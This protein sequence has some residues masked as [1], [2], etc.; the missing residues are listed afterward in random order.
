MLPARH[1][2]LAND[3]QVALRGDAQVQGVVSIHAQ[4]LRFEEPDV[5][6]IGHIEDTVGWSR[7]DEQ[8]IADGVPRAELFQPGGI[9]DL[10]TDP[11]HGSG[12]DAGR[13]FDHR[14]LL[15][16]GADLAQHV[17]SAGGP[18]HMDFVGGLAGE[19]QGVVDRHGTFCGEPV[20][21]VAEDIP[22]PGGRPAD[23]DS[24]VADSRLG[25]HQTDRGGRL[26]V[27]E[28]VAVAGLPRRQTNLVD[29]GGWSRSRA[30]GRC[31]PA[32]R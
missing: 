25:G 11:D 19:D 30:W 2:P 20:H 27:A 10:Q 9:D 31:R 24:V 8:E 16:I 32:P 4:V 5:P 23:G 3:L 18:G 15:Q 13:E 29:L 14:L 22:L 26:H 17:A 28:V 6:G 1:L 21:G 7:I 12:P